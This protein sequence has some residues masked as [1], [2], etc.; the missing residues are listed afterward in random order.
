MRNNFNDA[1]NGGKDTPNL[2]VT[3]QAVFEFYEALLTN[4]NG[5]VSLLTPSDGEKK[6][7]DGG[8]QKLGFKGVPITWD[9]LC[10]SGYLYFLNTKHMK[11]VVH[12]QA[13]LKTTAFVKPENQDAR[14]AQVLFMGN[15]T[16]D[17]CKSFALMTAVTS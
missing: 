6:L 15:L 3:T 7:G 9:E 10:T 13:N 1:S 2:L 16:C 14:V 4:F 12:S 8:F 11:M 17:R 5:N